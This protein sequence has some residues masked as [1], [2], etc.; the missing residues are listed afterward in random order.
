[1]SIKKEAIVSALVLSMLLLLSGVEE[2]PQGI[3]GIGGG[4]KTEAAKYGVDFTLMPGVDRLTAGKTFF[5][6]DTFYVDVLLENYDNE[7]KSGEICINDEIDDAYGGIPS[8]TCKSFNIA[9]ATYIGDTVQPASARIIFPDREAYSYERIPVALSISANLNVVISYTQ[10]SVIEGVVDA[11]SPETET[12]TL[13]QEAA[14]VVVTAE[15]SISSREGNVKATLKIG[16]TKQ[17]DYNITSVDFKRKTIA[18][19]YVLGNYGMECPDVQQGYF[20]FESTKFISCSALLPKEQTT[21][22]LQMTLDYGV[23]LSKKFS[24]TIKKSE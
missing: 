9:G 20:D 24:F 13:K 10:H 21:H 17:G 15:K 23:K 19:S 14:P 16:F 18:F 5:Q 8:N 22:F 1:M 6:G 11:P 2:C 3:G 12:L 4:G 7:A